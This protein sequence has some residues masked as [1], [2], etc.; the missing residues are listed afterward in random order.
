MKQ[1]KK[2]WLLFVL[3]LLLGGCEKE[4]EFPPATQEGKNTMAFKLNGREWIA[5]GVSADETA[6]TFIAL[7]GDGSKGDD[8][9]RIMIVLNKKDFYNV[10]NNYNLADSTQGEANLFKKGLS[11]TYG[12]AFNEGVG[13]VSG[14]IK[15]TRYDFE[16]AI[17]SGEFELVLKS[18]KCQDSV[19]ITEGRFD[20]GSPYFYR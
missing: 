6:G 7:Y 3:P 17:I 4:E 8:F 5:S 1:L 13:L 14:T 12:E 10:L 19:K 11:C 9:H 18:T 2:L 15:I 16:K 20:I